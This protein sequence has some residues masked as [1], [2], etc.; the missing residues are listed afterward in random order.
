MMR[1]MQR[2]LRILVSCTIY[3]FCVAVHHEK[4]FEFFPYYGEILG[5][6]ISGQHNVSQEQLELVGGKNCSAQYTTSLDTETARDATSA[7]YLSMFRFMLH[8]VTML[9]FHP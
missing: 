7:C 1:N 3:S 5:N 9:I 6:Q 8:G 4:F 2:F